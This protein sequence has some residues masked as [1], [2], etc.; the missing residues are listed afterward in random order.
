MVRTSRSKAHI[1]AITTYAKV[2]L[3]FE[4]VKENEERKECHMRAKFL[5]QEGLPV[6]H[7]CTKHKH[8]RP[9]LMQH[10]ALTTLEVFLIQFFVLLRAKGRAPLVVPSRPRW[11][12]YT[13]FE[14]Q[15]PLT[16][17]QADS[18]VYLQSEEMVSE[19]IDSNHIGKPELRCRFC[20]GIKAFKSIIALW[21]HFVH[22]HYK[23]FENKVWTQIVVDEQHLLE[24]IRR[25]AGSLRTYWREHSDGGKRRDPTM[26]KLSQVEDDNFAWSDVLEWQLR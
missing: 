16:F 12:P 26:M 8:K 3:V 17:C 18:A 20:S 4:S 10:A 6:P 21:S 13:T 24:E 11:H 2:Q 1:F 7:H 5:P 14:Y 15:L 9:C 25:T 22:Q 23:Q 19:V